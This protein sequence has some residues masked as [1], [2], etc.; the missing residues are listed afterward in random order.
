MAPLFLPSH[1][2]SHTCSSVSPKNAHNLPGQQSKSGPLVRPPCKH[3]S[4]A[5]TVV[6]AVSENVVKDS[7]GQSPKS[8][9]E[10]LEHRGGTKSS[11]GMLAVHGGERAGRPR[12]SGSQASELVE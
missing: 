2:L 9:I 10:P 12:V 7:E 4:R 1:R 8:D 3:T 6:K 11:P 5:N